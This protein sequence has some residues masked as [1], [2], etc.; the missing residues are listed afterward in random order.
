M[1]DGVSGSPFTSEGWNPE[2][3]D[4]SFDVD[5]TSDDG[6]PAVLMGIEVE[7]SDATT[8]RIEVLD[9]NGIVVETVSGTFPLLFLCLN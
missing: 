9:S 5:V 6:E 1:S 8:L 2:G 7:V 4:A 3:L